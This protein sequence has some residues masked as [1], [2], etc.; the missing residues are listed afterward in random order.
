[1]GAGVR[2]VAVDGESYDAPT[3]PVHTLVDQSLSTH[4]VSSP[5]MEGVGIYSY[6][7]DVSDRVLYL[8]E[9]HHDCKFGTR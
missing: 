8:R 4:P 5:T 1:M 2:V 3:D 9:R 7:S 6:A